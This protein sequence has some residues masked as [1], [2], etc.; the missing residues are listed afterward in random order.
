MDVILPID[1][2]HH[3]S[4]WLKH[5][6]TT[7]QVCFICFFTTDKISTLNRLRKKVIQEV[8]SGYPVHQCGD[9]TS[10]RPGKRTKNE[11][12]NHHF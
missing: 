4:R 3:V 12:E 9:L 5:V 11:L 10:T 1:E 7:N 8:I 6:K 2:L